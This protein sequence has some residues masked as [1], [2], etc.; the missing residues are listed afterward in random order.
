MTKKLYALQR[1]GQK[2]VELSYGALYRNF[3][4]KLDGIQV[5]TAADR[6]ELKNGK[7]FTLS[8]GSKLRVQLEKNSQVSVYMNDR[9]LPDSPTDPV[10][11]FTNAYSTIFVIAV[12]TALLSF[13]LPAILHSTSGR[14]TSAAASTFTIVFALAFAGFFALLGWLVMQKIRIALWIAIIVYGIDLLFLVFG[15]LNGSSTFVAGI[16]V[17]L[18][19]LYY[20]YKG[21]EGLDALEQEQARSQS[22]VLAPLA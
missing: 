20:M 2:R 14:T 13:V 8:N 15:M 16:P 4:V 5:G 17:H 6:N 3:A 7:T 18:F 12:W 22:E 10:K 21:F 9:P 19:F 11:K 1:K